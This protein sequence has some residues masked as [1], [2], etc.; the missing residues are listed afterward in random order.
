MKEVS[1]GDEARLSQTF[2]RRMAVPSGPP[3]VIFSFS[4]RHFADA[5]VP[6]YT[7]TFQKAR[8]PVPTCWP[9][10]ILLSL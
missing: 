6:P 3:M 1:A 2:E 10:F 8:F 9:K 4:G 7:L 5:Y